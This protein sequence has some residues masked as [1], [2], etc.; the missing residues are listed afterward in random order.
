M[1][2]VSQSRELNASEV[3][4]YEPAP[5]PRSFNHKQTFQLTQPHT[6]LLHGHE[7]LRTNTFL[8]LPASTSSG[9]LSSPTYIPSGTSNSDAFHSTR[10]SDGF[11][12]ASNACGSS[13]SSNAASDIPASSTDYSI[14]HQLGDSAM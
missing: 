13:F 12:P 3:Y 10:P 11:C 6:F 1:K 9:E 14:D 7:L 8:W 2:P 5:A 4:K